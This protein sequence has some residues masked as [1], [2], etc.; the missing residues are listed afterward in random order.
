MNI[1]FLVPM[2]ITFGT[3]TNPDDNQRTCWKQ[4]GRFYNLPPTDLPLGILSISAFLK[5][6]VDV[7]VELL[8]FNVEAV[9]CATFAYD[10][11]FAFARDRL[12]QLDF[13][14]DLIGISC[15]FSP[16]FQNFM[17]TGQAARQVFADAIIIGGG[18]IPTSAWQEIWRGGGGGGGGGG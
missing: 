1:L 13:K 3:F 8:D 14:P 12:S 18:N 6:Y 9:T 2:H 15:L 7:V 10:S 11:F 5:K 4:D 17:E 16:A